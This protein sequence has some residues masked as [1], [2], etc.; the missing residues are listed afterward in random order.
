MKTGD[1]ALRVT[2]CITP[3]VY[4]CTNT[5]ENK[6]N[7]ASVGHAKEI[8]IALAFHQNSA[9]G[10]LMLVVIIDVITEVITSIIHNAECIYVYKHS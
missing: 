8:E 7:I 4:I 10:S 2:L 9:L 5:P 3:N 1:N 6:S